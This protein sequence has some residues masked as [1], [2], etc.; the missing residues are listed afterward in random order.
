MVFPPGQGKYGADLMAQWRRYL[1]EYAEAEGDFETQILVGGYHSAEIFGSLSLLLDREGRYRPLIEA[2]I[3]YFREGSRR[4]E[5]FEDRL[6]NATFTLYN[7]LNTLSRLFAGDNTEAGRLIAAVDAAVQ[8]RVEAAGPIERAAAAL[9][10]SFPLLSLMTLFVDQG[11]GMA[12]A[13]RQIEQRFAEGGSRA[14]S[15]WER[16]LNSLYRLVEMMQLFAILSDAE[17]RDQVG[18]IAARFKEEDQVPDLRLKLRN[19]FCR[20]FELAHLVTTH[21][22]EVLPA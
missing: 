12:S 22:D 20:T 2:R 16:A 19:G 13:V 18:Q 9:G 3:G 15:D 14:G 10:A 1:E 11:R 6:I 7:H 5:V 8:Q 21:L 4:A 17:L